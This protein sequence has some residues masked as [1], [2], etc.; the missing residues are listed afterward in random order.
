[1]TFRLRLPGALYRLATTKAGGEGP[2]A[3]LILH[4]ITDYVSGQTEAQRT[5]AQGGK[6]AAAHM[7]PAQRVARAKT[8]RAAQLGRKDTQS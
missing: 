3:D 5:G 7:T 1:M 6:V 4:W 8:A 2:L